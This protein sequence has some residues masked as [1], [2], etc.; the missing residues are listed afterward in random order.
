MPPCGPEN[1]GLANFGGTRVEAMAAQR[2]VVVTRVGGIPEI[3]ADEPEALVEPDSAEALAKA[4]AAALYDKAR[5]ET[6]K[7]RRD[8]AQ[9]RFSVERMASDIEAAYRACLA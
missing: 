3:F 9:K 5:E 6:A 2:P 4:M 1:D 8:M 7:R